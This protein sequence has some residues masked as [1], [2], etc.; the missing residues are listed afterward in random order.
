MNKDTGAIDPN[1][2]FPE[3]PQLSQNNPLITIA[4]GFPTGGDSGQINFRS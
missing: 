3:I 1:V 4:P 2:G